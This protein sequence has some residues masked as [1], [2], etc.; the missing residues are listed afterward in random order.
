MAAEVAR[1]MVE[2]AGI[3]YLYEAKLLIVGEAGAGKTTLAKKIVNQDYM[4]DEDEKT[5]EFCFPI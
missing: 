3:D 5:T 2:N 4:L 1:K